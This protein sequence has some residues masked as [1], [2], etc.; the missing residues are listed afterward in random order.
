MQQIIEKKNRKECQIAN[1]FFYDKRE[2]YLILSIKNSSF[3][4]DKNSL[5]LY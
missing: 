4:L 2:I 3:N 1:D 5:N